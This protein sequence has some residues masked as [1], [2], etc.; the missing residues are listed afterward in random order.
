[1]AQLPDIESM[2]S[3]PTPRPDLGVSSYQ[4]GQV[5]QAYENMGSAMQ[6]ASKALEQVKQMEVETQVNDQYANQYVPQA[7][8]LKQQFNSLQSGDAVKPDPVTGQTPM[9]KYIGDLQSLR[10]NMRDSIQGQYGKELFDQQARRHVEYEL[11][12]AANHVDQQ[13]QVYEK[14]SQASLLDSFV[15][16]SSNN[17]GDL[18]AYQSNQDAGIQAI[19]Q[20]GKS[21]GQPDT[22]IQQ[23]VNEFKSQQA[24]EMLQN[25]A[26]SNPKG[27]LSLFNGSKDAP[28]LSADVDPKIR[29]RLL[30][31]L[32]NQVGTDDIKGLSLKT[33][34]EIQSQ[35]PNNIAAQE[36]ELNSQFINGKIDADV[37]G[38]ALS[39]LRADNTQ[40]HGEQI[41]QDKSVMGNIWDGVRNGT[42]SSIND[43]PTNT[44]AYI[45]QRDLGPRVEEMLK[46]NMLKSNPAVFNETLSRIHLPD[47]DPRKISNPGQLY[48]LVDNGTI[49]Y[50]D[51]QRLN[52]EITDANTPEGNPFL[53]QTNNAKQT[54]RKMLIGSM[55]PIAI[56][57]PDVAEESAFRFSSYLDDKIDAMRK[58]GKDPHDLYNPSSPDYVLN[59]SRVASFMPNEQ[60]MADLKAG[61]N[62]GISFNGFTFPNQA[63]LDKYKTALDVWKSRHG[64]YSNQ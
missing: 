34:L 58:A 59:P 27:A 4:P 19:T 29:P 6:N 44:L 17:P 8:V 53:K 48:P 35:F 60:Q 46:G 33:S 15:K 42:I 57:Y 21:H 52:K 51:Q 5:S 26:T 3:S 28:G 39:L 13:Q 20:F 32:Q 12:A 1:M 30:S 18:S 2:G 56:Q 45:K 43:I 11:F 37:H 55:S 22:Y 36:K 62:G 61:N 63:A 38:A 9:D 50:T 40:H 47:G 24:T 16:N 64:Q 25:F 23:Q 41:E 10:N 49:S 54:A 31:Y 7:T 14:Q